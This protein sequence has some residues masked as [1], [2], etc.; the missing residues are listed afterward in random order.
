MASKLN[1]ISGAKPRDWRKVLRKPAMLKAKH[2]TIRSARPRVDYLLISSLI[3]F[4][5]TSAKE[6]TSHQECVVSR[7]SGIIAIALRFETDSCT[8][9]GYES[10]GFTPRLLLVYK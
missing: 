5:S 3:A 4:L 7:V 10:L 6:S 9:L 8:D 2:W 1:H